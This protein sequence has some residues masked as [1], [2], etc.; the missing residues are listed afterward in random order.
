MARPSVCDSS[1]LGAGPLLSLWQGKGPL[2]PDL[3]E[4]E[5]LVGRCSH[6]LKFILIITGPVY[7]CC[8]S[9]LSVDRCSDYDRSHVK[10]QQRD[11]LVRISTFVSAYLYINAT[12]STK[13]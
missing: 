8:L 4:A 6:S 1:N 3:R 5:G 2:F 7:C 11:E 9:R 12:E 10:D 13:F